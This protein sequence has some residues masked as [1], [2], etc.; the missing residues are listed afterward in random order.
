MIYGPIRSDEPYYGLMVMTDEAKGYKYRNSSCQERQGCLGKIGVV[1]NIEAKFTKKL[2][3]SGKQFPTNAE[4]SGD[5][6]DFSDK[7]FFNI[8]RL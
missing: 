2:S 7:S 4:K 1:A 3:S 6:K 5:S 8:L